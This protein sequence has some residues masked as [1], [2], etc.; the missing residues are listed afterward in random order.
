MDHQKTLQDFPPFETEMKVR[1]RL[2]ELEK[3]GPKGD[4]HKARTNSNQVL[5]ERSKAALLNCLLESSGKA[6]LVD[7]RHRGKRYLVFAIG[8]CYVKVLVSEGR[9][10]VMPPDRGDLEKIFTR[11]AV[12]HTAVEHYFEGSVPDTLFFGSSTQFEADNEFAI[13][14]RTNP[15]MIQ[16]GIPAPNT[17]IEASRGPI[18]ERP[19][20]RNSLEEILRSF[21]SM[22]RE[23]KCVPDIPGLDQQNLL[24]DPEGKIWV[25][26]TNTL[27]KPESYYRFGF[28]FPEAVV[29]L[30]QQLEKGYVPG[31]PQG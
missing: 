24:V 2:T 15:F 27:L 25:V 22:G 4:L 9:F 31:N 26:D 11:H 17:I 21:E 6:V 5:L 20:F 16:E 12:E 23:L 30:I 28:N 8:N 7:R 19:Q 18:A 14:M 10:S 3:I 13:A 1:D 29:H